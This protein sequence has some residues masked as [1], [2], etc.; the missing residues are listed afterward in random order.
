M[1]GFRFVC[2]SG[3]GVYVGREFGPMGLGSAL[4]VIAE[5]QYVAA[6]W[7]R[8]SEW[9]TLRGTGLEP[10]G[11]FGGIT[12]KSR[13]FLER[14]GRRRTEGDKKRRELYVSGS[15]SAV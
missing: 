6:S 10:D 3:F 15:R 12:T 14:F 2:C 7:G 9:A 5:I 1:W 11:K 8:A 4:Q 13:R